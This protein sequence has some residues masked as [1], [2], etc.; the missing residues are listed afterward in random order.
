MHL[1]C[2]AYGHKV[3][4]RKNEKLTFKLSYRVSAWGGREGREPALADET[5]KSQRQTEL[6]KVG[7]SETAIFQ[8]SNG[9]PT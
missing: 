4:I 3:R 2:V 5:L 6:Q 9:N 7:A 8:S 1:S